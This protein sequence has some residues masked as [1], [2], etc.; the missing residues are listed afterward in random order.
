M[1]P[2]VA[3]TISQ[4]RQRFG[5]DPVIAFAYARSYRERADSI[6]LFTPEL[7]L[8]P[9][10]FDPTRPD[11]TV[12]LAGAEDSWAGW[13]AAADRSPLSLAGCL[14]DAAP[15]AWGR[16]VINLCL[17]DNP[18]IDLSEMTYLLRSGSDRTGNL[19]FQASPTKYVPRGGVAT[20]EQLAAAAE[21]IEQ[22]MPI[23][24][25]LAAAAAH[26][27]SIGGA[28][29]KALLA[30]GDRQM[31]AKFSSSTDSRPVVKAEAVGM[32]MAGRVGIDVPHVEVVTT[33]G[34][35]DVLL[36]DRFDRSPEGQRRGV[37]SALTV[38]GLR[39]EESRYAGYGDIARAIRH[40]GWA[41]SAQ[42]LRELYTRMVLNIAISNTDDHLRNHAAFWNGH[43][44]RLTPAYDVSPQARSTSVT[45]HA[46]KLTSAGERASQFRVALKAAPEFL[47]TVPDA[48]GIIDHVIDTLTGCWDD[49]CDEARLTRAERDQLWKREFLNDYAFYDDA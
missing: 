44:L 19:D 13:P 21:L 4:L 15:D 36:V 30:E 49:V 24:D 25:G 1:E 20:L 8:R 31:V 41:D 9:G 14:R 26:G 35:K 46:I 32:L 47:L 33:T 38:L 16:R 23:P 22:G 43:D 18:D 42:Q 45:T 3:G 6:P 27:T 10:T 39:E 5:A 48:Q 17:D 37:V 34:G 7:P 2:V 29:P 28:R 11:E 12:R 40:P